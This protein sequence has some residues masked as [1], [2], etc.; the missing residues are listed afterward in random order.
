MG[1]NKRAGRLGLAAAF[2]ATGLIA[3]PTASAQ[4]VSPQVGPVTHI[5]TPGI[6]L[7]QGNGNGPGSAGAPAA[8]AY[9]STNWSGYAEDSTNGA[10]TSVSTTWIQPAVSCSVTPNSYAAFWAGLDGFSS[11]SVEQDGTLAECVGSGGRHGSQTAL[12]S[13]WY[14]MYP[15]PMVTIKEPVAVGDTLT[16][17][18]TEQGAGLFNLYLVDQPASGTGGWNYETSATL[19]SAALS[20]AE[21]IAE[22]PSSNSGVLPLADFG[23]VTFT[24]TSVNGTAMAAGPNTDSIEMV[25]RRGSPEAIPS[26]T[27][28]STGGFTVQWK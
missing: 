13:A 25:S 17:T 1:I 16:A 24:S 6:G 12:Y 26:S 14:E 3:V 4:Q 15:N 22:A 19:S 21:A 7:N 5:G 8:T 23:L 18:V 9:T 20:S 10:Y 11:G 27:L 28:T 2:I